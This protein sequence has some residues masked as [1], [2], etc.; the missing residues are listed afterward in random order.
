MSTRH[1][2]LNT[3]FAKLPLGFRRNAWPVAILL[4]LVIV[5][6][7]AL[8]SGYWRADDSGHTAACA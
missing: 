8:P 6:F 3:P 4:L 5:L 2:I 7:H 1:D